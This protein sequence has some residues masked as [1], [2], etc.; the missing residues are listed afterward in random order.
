MMRVHA[1]AWQDDERSHPDARSFPADTVH[2]RATGS[3]SHLVVYCGVRNSWRI[4]HSSSLPARRRWPRAAC[5]AR[6]G[7]PHLLVHRQL[8]SSLRTPPRCRPS[9]WNAVRLQR[10]TLSA[11]RLESCPPSRGIRTLTRRPHDRFAPAAGGTGLRLGL[12]RRPPALRCQHLDQ[13]P[14]V[15]G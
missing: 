15:A 3:S 11:I 12:P 10:G 9:V 14:P 5:P 8:V 4:S 7:H 6:N 13:I 2:A 1:V